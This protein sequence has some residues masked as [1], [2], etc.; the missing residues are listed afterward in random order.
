MRSSWIRVGLMASVLRREE[1]GRTHRAEGR[2]KTRAESRLMC[3]H[4][5]TKEH[6]G[7]LA[8]PEAGR[9]NERFSSAGSMEGT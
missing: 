6:Q 8:T 1:S 3:S 5:Q 9:S 2:G 7:L 4:I